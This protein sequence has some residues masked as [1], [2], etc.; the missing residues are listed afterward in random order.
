MT[1]GS[2]RV[3]APRELSRHPELDGLRG[4]A[5]LG[6]LATHVVFLDHG[7]PTWSLRGGFLGVDVFLVLSGFLIGGILVREAQATGSIDGARFSRRRAT[8]LLPPLV[9]LLVVQAAVSLALGSGWVE[10]VRQIV[11]SLTFTANWQMAFGHQPPLEVLHLWSLSLEVQFYVIA[12]VLIFAARR[13]LGR[14]RTMVAA[15][16]AGALAVA[17]W[18][19]YLYDHGAAPGA[20]YERTDT[21]LDSLLLGIAGVVVWRDRL[22]TDR[23]LQVAGIAGAAVLAVCWWVTEP[24]D[25]WLYRGGFTVIALAAVAAV[26]AATTGHGAVAWIG[27]RRWLRWFGGISF[28]LYLW[29]LPLYV[30]TVRVLPDAPLWVVGLIAIP[31]SI[32]AAMCSFRFVE[33]RALAPWRGGRAERLSDRGPG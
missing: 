5:I 32:A 22:V 27:D 15:L 10:Q 2:T 31:A 14:P 9:V 11:L 33:S 4:L 30:W 25:P 3:G 7:D 12:A 16:C 6:V 24:T 29:H 13:H 28:S 1:T 20:L 19:W 17:C 23:V 26:A 21:R 8:R 18:R